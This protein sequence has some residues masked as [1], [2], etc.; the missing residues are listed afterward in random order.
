MVNFNHDRD[1]GGLAEITAGEVILQTLRQI[2]HRGLLR[3]IVEL[4][5]WSSAPPPEKD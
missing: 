4:R 2:T 3:R 1:R 5:G